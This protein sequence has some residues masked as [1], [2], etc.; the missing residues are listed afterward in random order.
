MNE[1]YRNCFLNISA[2]FASNSREGIFSSANS[3]QWATLLMTVQGHSTT[4]DINGKIHFRRQSRDIKES[5]LNQRA[6]VLQESLLSPRVLWYDADQLRWDCITVCIDEDIPG[7]FDKKNYR[8]KLGRL[9]LRNNVKNEDSAFDIL[10]CWYC[11][12]NNFVHR[13]IQFPSDR[14]PAIAGL[15]AEVSRRSG[16]HYKHGLWEE[17]I[18]GGLRWNAHGTKI[19]LD[20]STGIP[21]WSWASVEGI[22]PKGQ[23]LFCYHHKRISDSDAHFMGFSNTGDFHSDI[24]GQ[25]MP[26]SI[27]LNGRWQLLKTSNR[28]PYFETNIDR[29]SDHP[30]SIPPKS[31]QIRISLDSWPDLEKSFFERLRPDIIY[32]QLGKWDGSLMPLF[33]EQCE[34]IYALVLEPLNTGED[35]YRR[36]GIAEIPKGYTEAQEW[37]TRTVN[38]F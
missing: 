5:P 14:L 33:K 28:L 25:A 34:M 4:H 21:S 8:H 7:P 11:Y 23:R 17:D 3:R 6:W 24:P 10:W 18:L 26:R 30:I 16:F 9:I 19:Q 20:V 31:D 29:R 27:S 37:P 38:I 1:Y 2:S 12:L 15:A 32:F 13:R 22:S 35:Q 36:I